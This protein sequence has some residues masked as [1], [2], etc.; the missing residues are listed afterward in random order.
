MTTRMGLRGLWAGALLAVGAAAAAHADEALFGYV[1]TTDLLPKG[2][3]EIEQ[4]ITDREGQAYGDFHHLHFNTELEYGLEDNF[5]VSAY[6]NW[7][8]SDANAN[9]VRHLTE[10]IEVPW[11]HDPTKPYSQAR[12][13][14][15]SF[16]AIYRVMSPYTDP[17]GLAFY[18]EPEFGPRE[19]GIEM[20]AIAQKNFLDDRLIFAGNFW[21]ELEHE[22]GSNL[23]PPGST[24]VPSP[25]KEDDTMAEFDLGASYRFV[26]NWSVGLEFRNHNEYGGWT[27]DHSNQEHT[28]F[29]LG[30]NIHYG[31]E[32]WWF[33]LSALR[34]IGSVAY[35]EDNKLE[36]KGSLL[37]GD[38]H[39]EWDG[40]RLKIG[41]TF[42]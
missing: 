28:A 27:L 17:F 10:G 12:W 6:L 23:V 40:L 14:G 21:V 31:G 13:D 29:F 9:S 34:Q 16:E 18:I 30:P 41:Y 4:W 5:Q 42:K 15:V 2:K 35:S 36:Q 38:E 24:D 20:R 33:T 3:Y 25:D 1:Y 7:S 19:S 32:R 37:F 11:D 8:Y 39:A 26:P 22:Q